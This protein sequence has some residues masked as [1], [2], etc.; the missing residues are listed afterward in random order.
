MLRAASP[1]LPAWCR[2]GARGQDQGRHTDTI[3]HQMTLSPRKSRFLIGPTTSKPGMAL[4]ASDGGSISQHPSLGRQAVT[5]PRPQASWEGMVPTPVLHQS[6]EQADHSPKRKAT[7][8]RCF[9][10]H[11]NAE[12]EQPLQPIRA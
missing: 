12:G 4:T 5:R 7:H 8:N 1:L 6:R 10:S 3:P 2:C 9:L 11:H